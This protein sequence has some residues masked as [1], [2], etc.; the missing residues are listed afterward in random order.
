MSF[1]VDAYFNI[2]KDI[3]FELPIEQQRKFWEHVG[4]RDRRLVQTERGATYTVK[5]AA[6][7]GQFES[8]Q[9]VPKKKK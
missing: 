7:Q 3:L 1:H 9:F 5:D 6:F 8:F 2:L 4:E